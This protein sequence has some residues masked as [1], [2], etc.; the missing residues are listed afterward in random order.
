VRVPAEAGTAAPISTLLIL[1]AVQVRRMETDPETRAVKAELQRL[2][3]PQF[4]LFVMTDQPTP[5]ADDQT[6]ENQNMGIYRSGIM[7]ESKG[8][9]GH[10]VSN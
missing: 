7:N 3:P 4:P 1:L 5:R 6:W 2:P 10:L 8:E 9:K